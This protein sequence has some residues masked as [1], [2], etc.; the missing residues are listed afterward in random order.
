MPGGAVLEMVNLDQLYLK[1]YVPESRIGQVKLGLPARVY[2]DS[3]PDIYYEAKVTYISARAEF[4]PKEVQTTD[5]RVKLMYAV[6][7]TLKANPGH[8]L[9]PGLPADAV[10]RCNDSAVWQK[11]RWH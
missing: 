10:I 6:K 7:L 4:T 9:T 2:I 3:Q 11:P 1:V 5:E 8:K